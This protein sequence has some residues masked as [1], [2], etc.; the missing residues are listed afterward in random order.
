MKNNGLYTTID[1]SVLMV[2]PNATRL[3]PS[4]LSR[5][6]LSS[7][8]DSLKLNE[9]ISTSPMFAASHWL[10]CIY[11]NPEQSSELMREYL[12]ESSKVNSDAVYMGLE[13]ITLPYVSIIHEIIAK[14]LQRDT[15]MSFNWNFPE[16]NS[17]LKKIGDKSY[18]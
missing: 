13:Q 17:F 16:D 5:P 2:A 3:N 18:R 6:I 10:S 8:A 1:K 11:E 12:R 9:I 14:E 4:P 15:S 7:S